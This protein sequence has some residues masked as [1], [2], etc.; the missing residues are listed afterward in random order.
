M[1]RSVKQII[2]GHIDHIRLPQQAKAIESADRRGLPEHPI[3][4]QQAIELAYNW[5]CTAQDATPDGGVA[6]DY[7]LTNGWAT[8]YPETTGYIVPTFLKL[9]PLDDFH[10]ARTRA[11]RMLDWLVSIQFEEGGFQGG[12]ADAQPLV[13]V[14]FNTG[15][16]LIGLAAGTDE[17]GDAYRLPML[18]AARWLRDS[19]DDDGCWRRHPTPFAAPGEKAYETHVAW[20]LYEAARM[21]P[22]EGFQEAADRNIYWALTKQR[23]NGW[24]ADCCLEEP[25]APLTHTLGYVLRGILEAYEYSENQ[26]FLTAVDTTATGLLG[27]LKNDGFLAGRLRED[28]S[29]Q[30]DWACL[31]GSVQIAYCWLRLFQITGNQD[32]LDAGKTA[33]NYVRRTLITQGDP[34]VVGGIRGSFPIHGDYGR[35]EFLNWA[36]KFFI[37][38]HLK[39]L[40]ESAQRSA[41]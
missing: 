38:S 21:E 9:A 27:A 19:L 14:T 22:G 23:A 28:W 35:F 13:P 12:K 24:F 40:E 1:L 30:V 37:D 3:D 25:T 16:I 41:A 39:E 4:P 17:F 18:K 34:S 10:D 26:E 29:P 33:N 5:L 2:S 15:Q 32:Y 7:S 6:R 31:T 11:R 36:A 8:S 20:G